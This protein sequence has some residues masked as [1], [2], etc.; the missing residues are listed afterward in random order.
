MPNNAD[1]HVIE[2][3]S[4]P[5]DQTAKT[6]FWIIMFTA[7]AFAGAVLILIR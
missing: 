5:A 2:E 1:T 7:A 3:V 4:S 6:V